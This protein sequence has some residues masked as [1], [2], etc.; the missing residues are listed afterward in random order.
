MK[1]KVLNEFSMKIADQSFSSTGLFRTMSGKNDLIKNI[2]ID[3]AFDYKNLAS[4]S[5]QLLVPTWT[6]SYIDGDFCVYDSV[7]EYLLC[8]LSDQ[9]K[10]SGNPDFPFL[11][12][13]TLIEPIPTSEVTI[14]PDTIMELDEEPGIEDRGYINNKRQ[15][16]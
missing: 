6:Q 5:P 12:R 2:Y 16:I 15:L 7:A 13:A 1:L 3:F 11:F 8:E 4:D 10:Y 14:I 9:S